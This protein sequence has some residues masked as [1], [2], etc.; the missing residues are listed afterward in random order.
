MCWGALNRFTPDDA[1]M[2]C[3]KGETKAEKWCTLN[4]GTHQYLKLNPYEEGGNCGE[5]SW[6]DTPEESSAAMM[7]KS[8]GLDITDR[9]MRFVSKKDRLLWEVDLE[10]QTY[11]HWSTLEGFAQEPDNI[12]F[13]GDTLYYCT[14]G[15]SPNGLYGM[16]KVG[17][18]PILHEIDYQTEL[19]GVDFTPD[20][21]MIYVAFQDKAIWQFW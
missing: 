7:R 19:A 17:Y 14:D 13:L 3:Y 4:S 10:E 20:K 18:Y 2:E 9:I 11:C 8:E 6:V 16:N 1:A 12:R 5:I 21:K 15:R